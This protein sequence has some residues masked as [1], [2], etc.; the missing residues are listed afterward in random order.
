M[1][2]IEQAIVTDEIDSMRN[3]LKSKVSALHKMEGNP[4]Y[5]RHTL[6]NNIFPIGHAERKGFDLKGIKL[7][8]IL[9]S[10]Q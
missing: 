5:T 6:V 9:I 2:F 10:K 3:D 4:S 7:E 8:D 1:L